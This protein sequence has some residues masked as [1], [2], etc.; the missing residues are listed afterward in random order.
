MGSS[1]QTYEESET[2]TIN[3][4]DSSRSSSDGRN[5][6]S[7]STHETT[8]S[9]QQQKR[10][11]LYGHIGLFKRININPDE[12]L[13]FDPK[14]QEIIVKKQIVSDIVPA[15]VANMI[16]KMN[17]MS[18][19]IV[20]VLNDID[21]VRGGMTDYKD[22]YYAMPT[23]VPRGKDYQKMKKLNVALEDLVALEEELEK[24]EAEKIAEA[25]KEMLRKLNPE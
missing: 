19:K 15:Q 25:E 13:G 3:E 6:E 9:L 11:R 1:S 5:D 4:N 20:N 24:S 16:G 2:T 14:M 22:G 12:L 7:G 8:I 10:N 21:S 18:A 23:E 17:K